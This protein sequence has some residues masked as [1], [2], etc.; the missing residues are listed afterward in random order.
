MRRVTSPSS[1]MSH[2]RELGPPLC[3]WYEKTRNTT[4]QIQNRQFES[5]QLFQLRCPDFKFSTEGRCSGRVMDCVAQSMS[6]I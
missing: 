6:P 3:S 4:N 2:A 5:I 1:K